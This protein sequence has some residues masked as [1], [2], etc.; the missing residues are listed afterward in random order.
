MI[1]YTG[2]EHMRG[3]TYRQ[4]YRYQLFSSTYKANLKENEKM[5]VMILK[6][7]F[8]EDSKSGLRIVIFRDFIFYLRR[9]QIGVVCDL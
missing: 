7:I 3:K 8:H 5:V 4:M 6:L 9:G 2:F 1:G